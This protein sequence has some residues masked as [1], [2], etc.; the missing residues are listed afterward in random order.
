MYDATTCHCLSVDFGSYT[1]YTK[2]PGYNIYCDKCLA[3][4]IRMLNDMGIKTVG[5]CCG[6]QR[7][8]G[9]VQVA[10]EYVQRMVELGYQQLPETGDGCGKWCFAPKSVLMVE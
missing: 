8:Q 2:V 10:P 4:E 7:K 6:H 3:T 9:Y 1:C 5:C